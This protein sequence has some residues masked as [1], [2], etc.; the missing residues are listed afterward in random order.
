MDSPWNGIIREAAR[1]IDPIV[2]YGYVLSL[3]PSESHESVSPRRCGER[4][5]LCDRMRQAY[6]PLALNRIQDKEYPQLSGSP[7]C[8]LAPHL[9]RELHVLRIHLMICST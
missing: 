9:S 8:R 3:Y 4:L 6:V 7:I 2:Q 5:I 1:I